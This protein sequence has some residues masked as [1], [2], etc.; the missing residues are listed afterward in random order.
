MPLSVKRLL[1]RVRAQGV[2]PTVQLLDGWMIEPVHRAARP[3]WI[4]GAGHVGRALVGTLCS[5]PDLSITWIDTAQ[6]RFPARR[7][8]R[9]EHDSNAASRRPRGP[10]PAQRRAPDPD[11]FACARSRPLPPA[12]CPWL[13]LCRVDRIAHQMGAVPVAPGKARPCA[14]TDRRHHLSDRRSVAGQASA[15]HRTRGGGQ[16]LR[17]ATRPIPRTRT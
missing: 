11:L 5:L 15:I 13:R 1:D 14:G 3:V 10:C 4:W 6:D 12:A 7:A 8:G 2:S 16:L 9:C 17:P